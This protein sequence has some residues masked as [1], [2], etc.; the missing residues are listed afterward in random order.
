MTLVNPALWKREHRAALVL[1]TAI[2]IC[3]GLVVGYLAYATGSGDERAAPFTHWIDYS[4]D[5]GIWWGLFGG[6]MG[7]AIIYVVQLLRQ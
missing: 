4:F 2:G 5:S 6:T 1:T 7:A 3:L